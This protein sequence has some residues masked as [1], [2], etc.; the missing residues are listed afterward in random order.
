MYPWVGLL[1]DDRKADKA[2]S[3][4]DRCRIRC[5]R[6]TSVH[7]G[8][9]TVRYRPLVW[10]GRIL[11][12]GEPVDEVVEAPLAGHGGI[13]VGDWV[14]LHWQWV[15]DRLTG[16]QLRALRGYTM[17]HLDLVNHRVAHSGPALALGG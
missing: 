6:V 14:S 8:Q 3:V 7:N 15:C 5:G 1:G 12:L 16:R 4:L 17:R 13:A 10:D 11:A 9:L 2:L